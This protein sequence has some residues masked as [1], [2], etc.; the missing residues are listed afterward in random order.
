MISAR[1]TIPF[2]GFL[3]LLS[4]PVNPLGRPRSTYEHT[5][6]S[7][8]SDCASKAEYVLETLLRHLV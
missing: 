5:D 4:V 2:L 3:I 6:L 1:L 8:D 7:E